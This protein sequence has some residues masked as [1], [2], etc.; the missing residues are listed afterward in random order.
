[1]GAMRQLLLL[2]VLLS[3]SA[4]RADTLVNWELGFEIDVPTTWL[5]QEGGANGLKLASDDVRLDVVPYSGVSLAAEI[6]RL[7]K[8]TKADG[9]QFKS[10]KSYALHEVPA[11]EM[12]FYRDGRYKI[13]QVLM[14]GSRGFLL[15]LTSEGTD[16]EA[17]RQAQDVI[18]SFRVKPA[19]AGYPA[20]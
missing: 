10:E 1:M 5:R 20:P 4:A 18:A 16:S 15:T 6:E 13:Y 17:F 2:F 19:N 7:H 9:Y 14:A 11:H 3:L 8:Q 12:V